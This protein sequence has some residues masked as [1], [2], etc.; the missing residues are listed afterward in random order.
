[1]LAAA[2]SHD[3]RYAF[4]ALLGPRA[5][6]AVSGRHP[7]LEMGL[8]RGRPG[9]GL[10]FLS[11]YTMALLAACVVLYILVDARRDRARLRLLAFSA[12]CGP[13]RESPRFSLCQ[14]GFGTV[15]M[16]G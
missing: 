6:G 11:K 7:K 3:H 12:F 16:N 10:G 2:G 15:N 8:V 1:M 13:R 14:Y 4:H 5:L 9:G